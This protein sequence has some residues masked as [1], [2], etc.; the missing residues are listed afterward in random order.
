MKTSRRKNSII[1]ILLA[2]AGVLILAYP[3]I[4]DRWNAR[5]TRNLIT[6]YEQVL[7]DTDTSV[8][9]DIIRRC[10]EYNKR[11]IGSQVPNSF[12]EH[13]HPPIL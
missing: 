12:M 2:L 9:D 4:S 7:E 6:E 1:T 3:T 5:F 11:L 13:D 10:Q 8:K